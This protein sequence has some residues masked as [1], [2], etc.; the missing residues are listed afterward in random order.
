MIVVSTLLVPDVVVYVTVSLDGSLARGFTGS[1]VGFI[2]LMV[3]IGAV[4]GGSDLA[5]NLSFVP[6]CK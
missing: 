5:G 6:K 3:F 2:C 1:M 4:P